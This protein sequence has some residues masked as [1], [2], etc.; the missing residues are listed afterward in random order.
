MSQEKKKDYV[1]MTAA[2]LARCHWWETDA[3]AAAVG[4]VEEFF[5]TYKGPQPLG[6]MKLVHLVAPDLP[7]DC[8]RGFLNRLQTA[9]DRGMLDNYFD[10]GRKGPYGAPLVLW[11]AWKKP[12]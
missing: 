9:R 5:K 12:E 10:R 2:E 4:M 3:A 7:Q 1:D 11:H 8:L 6:T